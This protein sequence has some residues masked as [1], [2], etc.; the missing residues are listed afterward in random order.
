MYLKNEQMKKIRDDYHAA[1]AL[2]KIAK[3][4]RIQKDED[5]YEGKVRAFQQIF[6]IMGV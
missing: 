2:R 3:N 6:E 1:I 4:K 5:F